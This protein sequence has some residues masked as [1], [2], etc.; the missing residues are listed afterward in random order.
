MSKE[1][2]RKLINKDIRFD[3]RKL[4]EYRK[5]ISIEYGVS[6]TAE[7]SAMVT[8][9]R[10]KVIAGVKMELNTPYPDTPNQGTLMVNSE[11]LPLSNPEFEPGPPSIQA[12]EISRVIDRG[13]RES[14]SV[15]VQKLC[16]TPKEKVWGVLIDI[17]PINDEGNLFDAGALAAMA[18]LKD[19]KFPELEDDTVNYKKKTDKGLPLEHIPLS[20]TVIKIGNKY[21][22]DPLTEEEK[23][24]D[25]R[26]TVVTLENN[27]ICA[28]QKG[29]DEPLSD[30]DTEEMVKIAIEKTNELRKYL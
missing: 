29:G 16:I 22:V 17:C 15:D 4:Q 24:Y 6:E 10:T 19:A 23:A 27:K 25:A 28:L 12:I 11:L 20:C 30:K 18:A 9:G 7:G 5:P 3:G 1:Y 13:I 21:I 2:I 14:Q 26:L 8:I